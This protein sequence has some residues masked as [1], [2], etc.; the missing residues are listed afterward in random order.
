MITAVVVPS[1][2]SSSWVLAISTIIFAAGCSMSISFRIVTPSL[3]MVTSPILSMS[4]L[5]MPFGPRVDLTAA[6]TAFAAAILLFWASSPRFL[7]VPSLRIIMGC[8]PSCC[9]I[10]EPRS[11]FLS[12]VN[13]PDPVIVLPAHYSS[14]EHADQYR[15]VITEGNG[16][17]PS[18]GHRWLSRIASP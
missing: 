12:I 14:D 17:K 5:S 7:V 16:K 18:A 13:L 11:I 10:C 2:T 6:A 15:V 8:P 9:D 3:V 1:P 4:I